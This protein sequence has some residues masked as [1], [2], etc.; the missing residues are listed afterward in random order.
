MCV[1]VCV[2]VCVYVCVGVCWCVL[3]VLVCVGVLVYV[4]EPC[5]SSNGSGVRALKEAKLRGVDVGG[6]PRKHNIRE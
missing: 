5:V 3:A 2:C 4:S 6:V 1:C